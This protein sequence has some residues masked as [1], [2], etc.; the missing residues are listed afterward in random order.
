MGRIKTGIAIPLVAWEGESEKKI[1][2]VMGVSSPK[3]KFDE[4]E[5]T[6]LKSIAN[7]TG[8]AIHRLQTSQKLKESEEKYRLLVDNANEAIVVAQDGVLKFSN[9]NATIL[10]GF[11]AQELAVKSFTDFIHPDDRDMVVDRYIKSIKGEE[12]PHSYSFR[13]INKDGNIRWVEINAVRIGWDGK[14]ATLNFMSDI[15][16]RRRAEEELRNSEERLK[17]VF[18]SA[19]DPYYMM[20]LEGNF[21]GGNKATESLIGFKR[22]ELMG[23][24]LVDANLLDP[25]QIE[26]AIML[27]ARNNRGEPTGPDEFV[28]IR[29]DGTKVN[30]EIRTHPVRI[31][32]QNVILGLARDI[33]ERKRAEEELIQSEKLAGIGTL[34][35][36]I[37][38]EVNNPLAGI[39]GYAEIMQEVDDISK[40]REYTDKILKN[41]KRASDIVRWLS[42]YSREAKDTNIKDVNL[43]DIMEDAMEALTH[44]RRSSD[45]KLLKD[46]HGIPSIKGN[47]S[48]LLQIFVNLMNNA[49]DAMPRGGRLTLSTSFD[50]D[51]VK[52]EVKDTGMGIPEEELGRVFDP[53]FTTKEVGKGTGLGLYVISMIVKKHQGTINVESE[54]DKGT[55]FT[56]RFP[57]SE[58]NMHLYS[59]GELYKGGYADLSRSL[60]GNE[61]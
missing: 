16:E 33:T 35:S 59:T 44:T 25:V 58:S 48:E 12:V 45:V 23:R 32:D 36:G 19:P 27:L 60:N 10:T 1:L 37:A 6:L 2:G 21:I 24:N 31:K 43:E 57:I 8:L 41:T 11:S 18:E 22:E 47:R 30:V 40:I 42:R 29:K 61:D 46:F 26:K 4:S 17:I 5:I 14:P 49:V 34:A 7:H 38:H 54:M 52:V 55:T 50:K 20:D 39:M 15:T 28:L 3:V 13:I 56:V 9:P 53:F 51:S